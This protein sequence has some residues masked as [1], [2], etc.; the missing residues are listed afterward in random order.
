MTAKPALHPDTIRSAPEHPG[1]RGRA[2]ASVLLL[3]LA[4]SCAPRSGGAGDA[5]PAAANPR[6]RTVTLRVGSASLEAEVASTEDQRSRGLM[7][8]TRL[9]EG[10][11][12]LF[13]FE[14]DLRPAFWMKNTTIPLSLAYVAADG[15]VTQIIDLVPLSEE[16]RQSQRYV[17]YALEVPR[18]WFATAGLRVG[19]R[20]SIP[21][22]D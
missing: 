10:R 21:P 20:I 2:V 7:Y 16:P 22:L 11:G 13:V 5:G 19:D 4:L 17:R 18:G 8:R 6:L 9:D 12:M 15:T 14:S 3:L 1:L